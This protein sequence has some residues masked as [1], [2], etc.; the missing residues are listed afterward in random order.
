MS[1]DR[2]VRNG[3]NP[4]P[5]EVQDRHSHILAYAYLLKAS[6][7]SAKYGWAVRTIRMFSPPPLQLKDF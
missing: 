1:L 6:I 7:P 5:K 4:S 2:Q 3:N